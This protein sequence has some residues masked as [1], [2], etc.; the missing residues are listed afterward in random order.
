MRRAVIGFFL[1]CYA[2]L[3]VMLLVAAWPASAA[4]APTYGDHKAVLAALQ[5]QF[6]EVVVK[7]GTDQNGAGMEI[8]A[9]PAADP[10]KATWTIVLTN[11]AGMSCLMSAGKHFADGPLPPPGDPA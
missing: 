1:L 6:G 10:E 8:T 4:D 3:A 7:S 9:N 2:F 11:S 5:Q